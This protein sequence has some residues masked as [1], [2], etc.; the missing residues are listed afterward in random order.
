MS[1][2]YFN[3]PLGH[4]VIFSWVEPKPGSIGIQDRAPRGRERSHGATVVLAKGRKPGDALKKER[5]D[6]VKSVTAFYKYLKPA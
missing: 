4:G 6:Y 2:Q 5:Q 3:Y 1:A